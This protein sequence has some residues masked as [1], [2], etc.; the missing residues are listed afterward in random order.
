MEALLAALGDEVQDVDEESFELFFQNSAL[1]D[2]GMI[3]PK[4]SPLEL[5]IA[6]REFNITQSP[7]ALQSKRKEGTTGA[8]VWQTSVRVAEWLSSSSNVLFTSGILDGTNTALELGSGVSGI[9]P[10]I[11]VP[12]VETVVATDQEHLLK[13][14][15]ENITANV[16][17]APG[18]RSTHTSRKRGNRREPAIGDVKVFAL[19]WEED[20]VQKVLA[21]HGFAEGV[22]AIVACDCIFNYALIEPLMQTCRGICSLR[23]QRRDD[24]SDQTD[25]RPTV[26]VIAQQLRQAEVFEQWLQASL[27]WFRVWRAPDN[28]LTEGLRAGSGFAVHICILRDGQA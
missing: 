28:A 15:R 2:L 18:H 24:G 22:D 26:G 13:I 1:P 20:D 19:D 12:R 27:R 5:S 17:R 25:Q 9:V 11:L 21:S 6:G 3:D 16:I 23:R 14:M 10:C 8:A 4:T 7:G